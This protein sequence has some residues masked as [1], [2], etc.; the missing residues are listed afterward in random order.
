MALARR[1]GTARRKWP[2]PPCRARLHS[3]GF[4]ALSGRA[5]QST[6]AA[7]RF[8]SRRPLATIR[9]RGAAGARQRRG[10]DHRR[11]GYCGRTGED[12]RSLVPA[13]PMFVGGIR[14]GAAARGRGDGAGNEARDSLGHTRRLCGGF[15]AAGGIRSTTSRRLPTARA[16]GNGGS[17]MAAAG[18]NGG[19]AAGRDSI[20]WR[21]PR[22]RASTSTSG[23][24]G[25]RF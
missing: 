19:R 13:V 11:L 12:F 2:E 3:F 21:I 8:A 6:R 9:L 25:A 10:G 20:P 15:C 23:G 5:G 17:G 22:V 16:A 7:V 1:A 4:A 14:D 18:Q 24:E